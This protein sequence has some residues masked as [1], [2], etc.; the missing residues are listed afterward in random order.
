[1]QSYSEFH[2]SGDRKATVTRVHMHMD[3]RWDLWE[4]V[5]YINNKAIQRSSMKSEDVAEDFAESFCS[6]GD[7]NTMLLNEIING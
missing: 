2:G 3:P 5:L 7:G 1:M 4:V 6:G